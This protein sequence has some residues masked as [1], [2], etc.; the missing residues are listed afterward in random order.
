MSDTNERSRQ[1]AL[2]RVRSPRDANEDRRE[3]GRTEL[4]LNA[5]HEL[6]CNLGAT[7]R[8]GLIDQWV[9]ALT[10]Q[11]E[12]QVAAVHVCDPQRYVLERISARGE[13]SPSA[14]PPIDA[15]SFEY[16]EQYPE[17]TFNGHCPVELAPVARSLG[18]ETFYWMMLPGRGKRLMLSAGFLPASGSSRRLR[19]E[20]APHFALL[21]SHLAAVLDNAELIAELAREKSE[22]SASNRQLD[23]S[24]KQLNDAQKQLLESSQVLAEVSRRAGM[25]EVATGVLHNVGNALNSV[26]VSA[27]VLAERL[28][29]L[30]VDGVLR[31][32]ELLASHPEMSALLNADERGRKVAPYL[33]E[34][35]SHLGRERDGMLSEIRVLE[36][37]I[38]HI[39]AIVGKQQ[40]YARTIDLS[41]PCQPSQLADDALA[42]SEH[43]LTR[44]GVTVS[45][46]YEPLPDISTDRHKVLQ[47][48]VNLMSNAKQAVDAVSAPHREI[49]MRVMRSSQGDGVLFCVRDNGAGIAAENM[50]R[51]FRYGFTTREQGHGFGLHTSAIAANQLGG[52]LSAGSAGPGRGAEFTLELPLEGSRAQAAE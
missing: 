9:Q 33:V 6:S 47:I 35:G 34:L 20:D 45:R 26:N 29:Q 37:H 43:L 52:R 5:F 12:F 13:N 4:W 51:L 25:A 24:V 44:M 49:R 1:N 32:A 31:T 22:L 2:L 30:K 16:L 14:E 19:S 8:K 36:N 3:G 50:S 46:E 39:K 28:R 40:T 7:D 27:G 21:G 11:L 48:L 23:L 17:G 38:Q 41:Q 10:G 18:L 42:L 15:V